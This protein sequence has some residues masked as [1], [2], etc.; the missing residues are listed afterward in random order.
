M[1]IDKIRNKVPNPINTELAKD[2]LISLNI[3]RVTFDEFTSY[4]KNH[5]VKNKPIDIKT[6]AS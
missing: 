3:F 5:A 2:S 4:T 6:N 1:P